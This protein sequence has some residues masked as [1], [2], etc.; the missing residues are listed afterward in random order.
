MPDSATRDAGVGDERHEPGE[1]LGVDVE[2]LEVAGVDADDA[3]AGVDGAPGLVLVVH[4]DERG[5]AERRGRGPASLTSSPS[6][7]GGD[8]EQDEVGA[9][10]AGLPDLVVADHEV[11]AQHRDPH[12]GPN[13]VEVVE[14]AAEPA[15]L[16]EDA[17]RRSLP[18]PRRQPPGRPGRRWRR[19]RPCS[20]W[21]ASPRRSATAR[22]RAGR[23]LR[24]VPPERASARRRT[25]SRDT[26]ASRTARS[27]RTPV[28][29]SSRTVGMRQ[30]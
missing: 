28:T 1:G 17:D 23:P 20:G 19:G 5:H 26:A 6:V 13:G 27:S 21:R 8:D 16:G 3:G 7:E 9:V 12:G 11:L 22:A 29:I 10:G 15:L 25:S 2:G 4:L 30:G 24:R 18:R 14:A